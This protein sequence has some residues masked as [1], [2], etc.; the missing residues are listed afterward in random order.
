MSAICLWALVVPAW[1]ATCEPG[2]AELD[3]ALRL[4]VRGGRV[5][6]RRLRAEPHSLDDYL[7]AIADFPA[8]SLSG[9][10]HAAKV[11]F[12]INAYNAIV[13]RSVRDQYPIH[14]RTFVGLAFPRN[15]IWQIS[16]VFTRRDWVVA[17]QTLSL[18]DI[19]HRILRRELADPRVHF[20]LV[21]AARSCPPLRSTAYRE[22]DLDTSL[23]AQTRRFLSDPER[24]MRVDEAGNAVWLS[25]IFKWFGEDFL[26]PDAASVGDLDARESSLL[27]MIDDLG[28]SPGLRRLLLAGEIRVRYLDY[29]WQLNDMQKD[30]P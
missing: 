7:Q 13:L 20:A 4:S 2:L 23:E 8:L 18:D 15:S 24:G 16:R 27:R 14:G 6:Y 10:S 17:G 21:C 3:T 19:E 28:I 11:A 26:R 12:W 25:K 30:A 9:C 22:M 5:D 29:D 1:P